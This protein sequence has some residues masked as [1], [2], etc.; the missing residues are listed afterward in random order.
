MTTNY[1][2]Y[3]DT[4]TCNDF[5]FHDDWEPHSIL[6]DYA[7]D[8]RQQSILDRWKNLIQEDEDCELGLVPFMRFGDDYNFPDATPIIRD[9]WEQ[10][11]T[12]LM[13]W[14]VVYNQD[15]VVRKV[16][17]VEQT[18]QQQIINILDDIDPSI[19]CWSAETSAVDKI[20]SDYVF[21][22]VDAFLS[23]RGF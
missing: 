18:N 17:V 15:N 10:Q 2:T 6:T 20:T 12:E 3:Y 4:T 11:L 7:K 1:F 9:D 13:F 8:E 19:Y 21:D 5:A 22:Y 23:S 16:I 14:F